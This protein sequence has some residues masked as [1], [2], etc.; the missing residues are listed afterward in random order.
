MMVV[1]H[2]LNGKSARLQIFFE[3]D[4]LRPH[5]IGRKSEMETDKSISFQ[6]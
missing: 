5:T 6:S 1:R 2:F 3:N 4:S